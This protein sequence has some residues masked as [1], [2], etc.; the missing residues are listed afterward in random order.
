MGAVLSCCGEGTIGASHGSHGSFSAALGEQ[1]GE[2][3]QEQRD[4]ATRASVHGANPP[5]S[6]RPRPSVASN[7]GKGA[8]GPP[9]DG[10]A[11]V[12]SCARVSSDAML[13]TGGDIFTT[14]TSNIRLNGTST[15]M[16]LSNGTVTTVTNIM[17]EDVEEITTCVQLTGFLGQ[18]GFA[19]VYRGVYQASEVAV[20]LAMAARHSDP[21][22]YCREAMLAQQ[23]RHPHVVA[24]YLAR[25]AKVTPELVERFNAAPPFHPYH[26]HGGVGGL[27]AAAAAA[28]AAA[29]ATATDA[30][31]AAA[32]VAQQHEYASGSNSASSQLPAA[33]AAAAGA[34]ASGVAPGCGAPAGTPHTA[35]SRASAGLV[36]LP[37]F[38]STQSGLH[39]RQ[40]QQVAALGWGQALFKLGAV[41]DHTLM[42]IVQELCESGSLSQAVKA[43]VFRP[44]PGRTSQLAA[45]RMLVRTVTEICRGMLHLHTANILHGDLKPAN[46]LL[47]RSRKDRRG[48]VAKIADFGLS[49]VLR[50]DTS[51]ALSDSIGTVTYASPETINGI[52]AKSCDVWAFGVMLWEL[53][54][55]KRAY[56][57]LMPAQIMCGVAFNGLRPTWP[58]E[59]WPELCDIGERCLSTEPAARPGFAQL[60]EELVA[61]EE[62]MR[63]ESRQQS[64]ERR[65][66]AA[67]A[68]AAAASSDGAAAA[69][70]AATA[71]A[72]TPCVP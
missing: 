2:Q 15:N 21:D 65:M 9:R 56:Y 62:A 49:R 52:R 13:E 8:E 36:T 42:V 32:A 63:E 60:E 27:P 26:P 40:L 19:S 72:A 71:T 33:A 4:D 57:W 43:G 61:L 47:A 30:A 69:V 68:A 12:D 18:G 37:N 55:E 41:P 6:I 28:A 70:V 29:T 67:S 66:A 24:T 53:V 5:S 1:P 64:Y 50:S 20:K 31:T 14:T 22:T 16:L 34:A 44:Q 35:S 58:R 59:V 7:P 10:K 45:R 23:L 39:T 46:V 3:R 54:A 51:H 17:V 25:G 38:S 48:F 11:V